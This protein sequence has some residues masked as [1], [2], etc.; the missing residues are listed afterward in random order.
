[1]NRFVWLAALGLA[2]GA[3]CG[4]HM[5]GRGDAL[6]KS[7]KTIAI[8]AFANATIAYHITDRLSADITHEFLA[9]TRYKV[10]TNPEAADAVLKGTVT[11]YYT[12]AATIDAVTN[13]NSTAGMSVT[14]LITLTDRATGKVIYSRTI[15]GHDRYEIS[16]STHTYFEESGAA[17]DRVARDL[18][19]EIVTA[20]LEKF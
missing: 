12:A 6:P 11:K 15:E 18:A 9:R 5:A 7:I 1:M 17:Q 3:G 4:Y 16:P 13:R 14:V 19:K 8:P 20:I 2:L 10:V